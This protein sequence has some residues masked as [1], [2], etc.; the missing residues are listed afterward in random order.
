MNSEELKRFLAI[1]FGV[2]RIGIALCDPLFT[3]AYPYKTL[4]NGPNLWKELKEIVT[5]QSV[6]KI[7][8][9]MPVKENGQ[10]TAISDVVLKFKNQLENKFKI[11]VVLRDERY[12]SSIA[13]EF[14]IKTVTKKSKRREKG[15]VDRSAAAI[16]LQDYLDEKKIL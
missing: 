9:G 14:I 16:I 1:D 2:K 8:L 7:I 11:E 13:Q 3:F 10:D 5:L 15:L 12:T 6:S 4:L